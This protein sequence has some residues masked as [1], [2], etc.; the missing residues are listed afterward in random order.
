MPVKIVHSGHVEVVGLGR[1]LLTSPVTPSSK[2]DLHMGQIA[3][4]AALTSRSFA[5]IGRLKGE[6]SEPEGARLAEQDLRKSIEGFLDENEI[7][8]VLELEGKWN[9]ELRS[10]LQ[11]LLAPIP[12]SNS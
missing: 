1:V 5:V 12:L 7:K 9:R 8:F 2:A 3:E 10:A 11:E 4:E 6:F